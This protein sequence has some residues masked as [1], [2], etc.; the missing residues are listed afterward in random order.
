MGEVPNELEFPTWRT[1]GF[2]HFFLAWIEPKDV[3]FVTKMALFVMQ[4]MQEEA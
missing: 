2:A 3:L 4:D 1:S